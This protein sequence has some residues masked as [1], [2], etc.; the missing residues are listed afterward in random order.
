MDKKEGVGGFM[1]NGNNDETNDNVTYLFGEDV[2]NQLSMG[3]DDF[4]PDVTEMIDVPYEEYE[5]LVADSVFLDFVS[6]VLDDDLWNKLEDEF[7]KW[8]KD[9]YGNDND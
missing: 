3:F 2:H 1:D 9:N 8:A 4:D 7:E 6:Q 5:D